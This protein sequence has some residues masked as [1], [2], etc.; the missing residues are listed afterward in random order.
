MNFGISFYISAKKAFG[1][2]DRD[3]IESLEHLDYITILT[4]GSL[5]IPGHAMTFNVFT[6]YSVPF[7]M[8]YSFECT[9]LREISQN[10]F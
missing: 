5:P 8:F 2:F 10:I 6:S 1:I 7:E 4:I 9:S 3:C